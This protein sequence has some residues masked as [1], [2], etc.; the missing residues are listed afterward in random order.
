MTANGGVVKLGL[1]IS[2][3]PPVGVVNQSMV[4]A[5]TLA[6]SVATPPEQIVTLD[7]VG[8]TG[9]GVT[10]AVTGI[11]GLVQPFVTPTT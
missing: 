2:D 9:G 8:A 10:I 6:L 3:V 4:P 7:A 5:G 1:V 11:L